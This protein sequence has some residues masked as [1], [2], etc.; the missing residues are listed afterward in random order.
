MIPIYSGDSVGPSFEG[1][2]PCARE[3]DVILPLY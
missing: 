1:S 2:D 3:L